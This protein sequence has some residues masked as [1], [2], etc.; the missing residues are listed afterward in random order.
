VEIWR[1]GDARSRRR[2]RN[3]RLTTPAGATGKR[4]QR[5]DL[6]GVDQAS[7]EWCGRQSW[8]TRARRERV[9]QG[10]AGRSPQRL[11]LACEE[12]RTPEIEAPRARQR[13]RSTS[14]LGTSVEGAQ[15]AAS[16]AGPIGTSGGIIRRCRLSP[17]QSSC[18]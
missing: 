4:G 5:S 2:C 18:Q 6:S 10:V 11:H 9:I 1:C 15:R 7:R 17:F 14:P 3:A 16:A 12:G 13:P 8:S